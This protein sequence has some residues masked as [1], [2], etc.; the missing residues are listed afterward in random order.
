MRAVFES[1][2]ENDLLSPARGDCQGEGPRIAILPAVTALPEEGPDPARVKAMFGGIAPRY[3]LLNRILSLGID[4]RWRRRAAEVAA[5]GGAERIL[6]LCAGTGDLTRAVSR[7]APGALVVCCD[8]SHPML[9]RAGPKLARAG[10]AERTPRVEA[11]GLR[12]P[13]DAEAFD[14]VTVAFGVRNLADRRRGFDEMRRVLRPGGRMIVLEFSRPEGRILGPLYRQYLRRVV[15][16]LGDAASRRRGPYAYLARTIAA[17][18]DP[19]LFAGEIREGGYAAVRWTPLTG[20]IACL[21]EAWK[22]A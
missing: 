5:S 15:P 3:D 13:F 22:G 16:R 1:E 6:D 10:L 4:R 9:L 18:P 8:F 2:N 19:A 20:G 14:A 21:H 17:F 12:L 11:D 7:A